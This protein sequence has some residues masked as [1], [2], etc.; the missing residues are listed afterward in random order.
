VAIVP[1]MIM[2]RTWLPRLF[3]YGKTKG[4]QIRNIPLS[5]DARHL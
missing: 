5:Y 4:E 1:M 3:D 2:S